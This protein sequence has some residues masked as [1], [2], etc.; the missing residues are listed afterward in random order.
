V[1]GAD[2]GVTVD[3]A[4]RAISNERVQELQILQFICGEIVVVSS[5]PD[6]I[7]CNLATRLSDLPFHFLTIV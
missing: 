4:P 3:M 1:S 6:D 2:A 5:F 7:Q